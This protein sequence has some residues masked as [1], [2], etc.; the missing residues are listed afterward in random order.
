MTV[1]GMTSYS[2]DGYMA[3]IEPKHTVY[4]YSIYELVDIVPERNVSARPMGYKVKKAT[5][6]YY[7]STWSWSRICTTSD[8]TF[9]SV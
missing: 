8:W 9:C 6:G 2:R 4:L 5:Y 7:L 1:T 3:F